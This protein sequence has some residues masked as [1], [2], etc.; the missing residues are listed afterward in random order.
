[1]RH[2]AGPFLLPGPDCRPDRE[3]CENQ[4]TGALLVDTFTQGVGTFD[5]PPP[6]PG[7]PPTARPTMKQKQKQPPQS[8]RPQF[9]RLIVID[10]ALRAVDYPT[11]DL[12]AEVVNMN[13]KTIR[14]DLIF[15]KDELGAPLDFC[16][17]RNGWRY[18][19][20]NWRL[21]DFSVSQGD[22]LAMFL[23]ARV[24][25]D[26]RGT[27]AHAQLKRSLSRMADLLPEQVTVQWETIQQAHS[28]QK[29]HTT[30]QDIEIFR[31]LA[32]A[33][34]HRKQVKMVYWSAGRDDTT[35][36]TVDPWHLSCIDGEWYVVG[37]CHL[38][39]AQ[40][41]FAPNRVRKIKF[42]G[43][44]FSVPA[45]FN[46]NEFLAGS[47][48]VVGEPDAPLKTIRLAFAPTAA[49]YVKEKV[50]NE[51]QTL[52]PTK[53]GGVIFEIKLNSF[54]EIRRWILSWGSECQVLEPPELRA[55]IVQQAQGIISRNHAPAPR[56]GRRGRPPK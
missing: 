43:Q 19:D 22:L 38:R 27:P 18:T 9:R 42:T 25:D 10:N 28:V 11:V 6:C 56:T 46:I 33:V 31:K 24:L 32:D 3:F 47:F 20:L 44:S 34:L 1:M 12:L 5:S 30:R 15:M 16:R 29:S 49:R 54:I 51:S 37:W 14:R 17:E 50:W 45:S 23:G 41:T 39:K 36:R 48:R 55:D 4:L 21:P 2:D 35:V 8:K 53:D 13:P 7:S 52:S 40:R 26:F